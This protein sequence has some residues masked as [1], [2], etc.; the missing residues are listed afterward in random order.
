[1]WIAYD[2]EMIRKAAQAGKVIASWGK[3]DTIARK[4]TH[5]ELLDTGDGEFWYGGYDSGQFVPYA[6]IVNRRVEWW[7]APLSSIQMFALKR[8]LNLYAA[9]VG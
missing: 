1:M 7:A 5:E 6:L 8:R 9:F 4:A 3:R 2:I